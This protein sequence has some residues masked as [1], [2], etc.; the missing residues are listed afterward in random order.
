MGWRRPVWIVLFSI[1]LFGELP[2]LLHRRLGWTSLSDAVHIATG[3]AI[4]WYTIET[5]YLRRA[6]VLANEIA[7]LPL[8]TAGI[9][10]VQSERGTHA[11]SV[12]L[13]NIGNSVA[14]SVRVADFDLE[15]TDLGTMGE[16]VRDRQA[17]SARRRGYSGVRRRPYRSHCP[18]RGWGRHQRS[19]TVA[20]HR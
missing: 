9:E 13:R 4:L 20:S 17:G 3:I 1:A 5:S 19:P 14:L 2:Y 11:E 10:W 6:M 18:A 15:K 7:V 16:V 12:V 8:V